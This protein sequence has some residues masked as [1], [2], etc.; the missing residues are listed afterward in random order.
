[1]RQLEAIE[2]QILH[3]FGQVA[4]GREVLEQEMLYNLAS[5]VAR[6]LHNG[7]IPS[8]FRGANKCPHQTRSPTP[9][10]GLYLLY[11]FIGHP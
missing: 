11:H 3:N 10:L 6:S 2:N 1:M 8:S 9:L 5:R 4:E 7:C